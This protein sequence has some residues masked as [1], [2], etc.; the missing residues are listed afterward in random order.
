MVQATMFE[1][2]T[3]LSELVRKAQFGEEV[4]LTNGREKVPVAKIVAL[5]PLK[6][7]PFGLFEVPGA[8]IPADLGELSPEELALWNGEGE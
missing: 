7:R 8:D 4:I 1:A 5:Q 2:K 3:N 6:T